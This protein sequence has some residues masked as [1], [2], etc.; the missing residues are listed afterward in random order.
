[1]PNQSLILTQKSG[2]DL[3]KL[4]KQFNANIKKIN[5]L[6]QRLQNDEV[7]L[8]QIINRIQSE[9]I[10]LEQK[11]NKKLVELVYV[12]DKHYDDSFFKK[13]ERQKIADFILNKSYELI[14]KLGIE[15]LKYIHDKYA[16]Q[17]Y[18][19]INNPELSIFENK[20]ATSENPKGQAKTEEPK[21]K[22]AKQIEKEEKLR[23]A[24]KN[25]TKATRSIYTDLVKAFHPDREQDETERERKTEIMKRI[26]QAY[27][28]EDLFELLRL[29][30]ELQTPESQSFSLAEEHLKHYN[31]I[32]LEQIASL[33]NSLTEI[34]KQA[35][36]S[37]GSS[38]LFKKFGGDEIMMQI[39]FSQEINS[40]K[41]GIR[42]LESNIF[43]FRN[44]E[45]MRAFLKDYVFLQF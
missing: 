9:I 25:S 20:E 39:K 26:T 42:A 30:S 14:D 11:H 17:P 19:S 21:A 31:K 40:L 24:A 32:L 37:M 35:S 13:K 6:K 44:R 2:K 29:K 45:I 16:F 38:N 8:R 34:Q 7:V 4:Q 5:E 10:P 18:D 12:F 27:E 41:K 15:D 3:S 36:V 22:S 1:M 33:E 43:Q 23:E 28:K